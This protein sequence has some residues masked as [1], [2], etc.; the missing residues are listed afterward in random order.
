MPPQVC[1]GARGEQGRL[2]KHMGGVDIG[3]MHL[4][5]DRAIRLDRPM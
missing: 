2:N 5:E 1:L 4:G 3:G